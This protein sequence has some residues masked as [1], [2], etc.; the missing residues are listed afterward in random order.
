VFNLPVDLEKSKRQALAEQVHATYKAHKDR[1]QLQ[2][3]AYDAEGGFLDGSYI[4]QFPR[5]TTGENG[6]YGKRKEQARYHN[7]AAT[8][9]DFY[10]RKIYGDSGVSRES[11]NEGLN[12]W[13][14]DV[15]GAGTVM[16]DFLRAALPK[17]LAA[18]HVGIL[19]DKS[20]ELPAGPSKADERARVFLTTYLPTDM[21]DWRVSRDEQLIALKLREGVPSDDILAE[22]D[23]DAE[24]Q[25][26][27]WDK[28]EW[29][30]IPHGD[31]PIERDLHN[32]GLVPCVILRPFRSSRWPLIGRSL[33]GDANILRA[34]YNRASEEDEVLRDQAFSL[35][36]VSLPA[37]GEVDVEKA[38]T[39]LG[40][41]V[42]A[43][44]AVFT[45]G[46]AD[47]RTADMAVPKTV[48]ENQQFLIR[49]LYRM[50]HIPFEDDS[51]EAEA[52]DSIRLQH[53]E[54]ED[55]LKGVAA[56][57]QRVEEQL[58]K[59]YFAWSAPSPEQAES[60]FEAAKVKINY[61]QE[62]FAA[63]PKAEIEMLTLAIRAVPSPTFEK[64]IQKR[65][66]DDVGGTLDD[67]TRKAIDGEID[68]GL[69]QPEQ[70]IDGESLRT[71][72]AQRLSAFASEQSQ[73]AREEPAA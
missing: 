70:G 54:L 3:D 39:A 25:I 41:E 27:L 9:V 49:E 4:W 14:E 48:R 33:L 56:E 1:W 69:Q 34:L 63:D 11:S 53:E 28:D 40:N 52:A 38:K 31:Q 37:T 62:F 57:C 22:P 43:T 71:N 8:L 59:L 47:F 64:V 73:V 26:L 36:V 46:S 18:G 72:A 12:A 19:A 30:R 10:A 6:E 20:R 29:V 2:L 60:E 35:F 17:A 24:H 15:D 68:A 21:L 58:A 5:E 65:I 42:G 16:S 13:W 23:D 51:R 55:V 67:K 7:Y 50:A 32:L 44:R 66:V 45:Y 61:P